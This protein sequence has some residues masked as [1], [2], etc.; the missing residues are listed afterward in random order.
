MDVDALL[1]LTYPTYKPDPDVQTISVDVMAI[2]GTSATT[3]P[4]SGVFYDSE[5][6]AIVHRSKTKSSGLVGMKVWSWC[7]KRAKIGEKEE[8]K[9]QELARRYNTTLVNSSLLFY[10]PPRH[11]N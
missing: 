11:G 9:L 2:V 8:R 4:E 1:N 5:V 6:L 10:P 7:G 3:V